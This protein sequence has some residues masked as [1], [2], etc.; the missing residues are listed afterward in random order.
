[1]AADVHPKAIDR[2]IAEQIGLSCRIAPVTAARRLNTAPALWCELPDTYSQLISGALPERI[3]ETVVSETRHLDAEKRHTVDQQLKTARLTRMAFKAATA[4]I[5]NTAYEADRAGYV[6]RGRTE[7]RH[8]RV[9]IRPTPDTMA[10]LSA[11]LPV[12]QG[13]ACSLYERPGCL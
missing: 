5:R 1:M 3:A 11:Y 9:G 10:M 12:E 13:V 6:Q 2:G 4:C 8:R 7:R